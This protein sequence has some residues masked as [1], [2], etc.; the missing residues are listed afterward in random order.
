M[1]YILKLALILALVTG[2]AAGALSLVNGKTKPIIEAYKRME[3][4]KA[5]SEVIEGELYVLCDSA[6]ALPYYKVYADKEAVNLIGYVFTAAGKGYSSTIKTVTGLDSL[7]NV[8]GIKITSQQE[9]PGLGAKSQ[10]VLYGETEPW[11]QRQFY[12]S[13]REDEGEQPLKAL[14]IAVDKDGGK[15]H[16]ITG[17]TITGRAIAN[18]IKESAQALQTKLEE[19]R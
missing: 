12:L 14:T 19:Q 3:E 18:S 5:R 7:F 9:T 6:T 8:T 13:H 1:G 4:A 17:A 11:F 16:S 15:V 10:E 2:I